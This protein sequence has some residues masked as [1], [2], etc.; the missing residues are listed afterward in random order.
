MSNRWNPP[1][2]DRK[3]AR[4]RIDPHEMLKRSMFDSREASC[5]S[6]F[7]KNRPCPSAVYGVRDDYLVLDSWEKVEG[8]RTDLGELQFN[9][10][11]QGVTRDQMIGVVHKLDTI[12]GIE[13]KDFCIPL[14]PF[15]NFDP[16][17]LTTLD[18]SLASLGLAANGALPA[19]DATTSPQAQTPFCGRVA[20]FFKEI[21]LQSISS[22][23]NRR[24]HIEFES[25]V[26]AAGDRVLLRPLEE[27][28]FYLFT[29][30]IQDIHG[31]TVQLTSPDNVIRLPPD[32]LYNVAAS[33]DAGQLLT[34]AHV[35]QTNLNNL[36]VGDRIFIL[37]FAASS[38][39]PGIEVL[40]RYVNRAEGHIVGAGGFALVPPTSPTSGTSVTFRLNPDVDVST[41][42]AAGAPIPSSSQ[43]VV[44]IAKNR[45]R[46]PLRTR[47]V[48]A[49]LTNY[50]AP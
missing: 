5:D 33:A 32:S 44:R 28:G 40:N 2:R 46:I 38:A 1:A 39:V 6:H 3:F 8:S 10:A 50:I 23:N 47:G 13:V 15:D 31:L 41:W 18:P 4:T 21:G 36:A 26:D 16:A 11:V 20:M 17:S 42:F 34:F 29:D 19:G 43:I 45:I 48:V 7:E 14:L 12:I 22:P 37:G 27:E 30:P 25:A 24:F 35:D 9:L 49:R